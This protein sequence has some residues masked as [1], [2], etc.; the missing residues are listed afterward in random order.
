[1]PCLRCVLGRWPRHHGRACTVYTRPCIFLAIFCALVLAIP[2]V[3]RGRSLV[4][5]WN[6]NP[7]PDIAGYRLSYG[8]LSG[9]Y[10]AAMDVGNVTSYS[11]SVTGG[12]TYYFA[13]QAYDAM[14]FMSA[15]SAEVAV[16]VP[17]P[18]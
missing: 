17:L 18:T 15:Y 6:P 1:M 11:F 3:A 9:V 4:A 8:T 2:S 13:L 10:T 16:L 12:L 14:G 5:S 7:E